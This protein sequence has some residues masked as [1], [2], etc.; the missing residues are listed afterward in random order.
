MNLWIFLLLQYRQDNKLFKFIALS[1]SFATQY[2][3]W[4]S[5]VLLFYILLKN[6][7]KIQIKSWEN[8]ERMTYK[9]SSYTTTYWMQPLSN[10]QLCYI[11][12]IL[13]KLYYRTWFRD[14]GTCLDMKSI[15]PA[16]CFLSFPYLH[17]SLHRCT[18]FIYLTNWQFINNWQNKYIR[19][20][21]LN[22]FIGVVKWTS[23]RI[24]ICGL[25]T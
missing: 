2:E 18:L 24:Q 8:W 23:L 11:L 6:Q 22:D 9:I 25:N 20:D 5:K 21:T 13:Q 4:C 14:S 7:Y 10:F 15:A 12:H 19:P 1:M 3:N 16:F 17:V